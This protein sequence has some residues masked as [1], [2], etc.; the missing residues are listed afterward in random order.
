[1]TPCYLPTH[2]LLSPY[3]LP[4]IS[5]RTISLRT[6]FYLLRACYTQPGTDLGYARTSGEVQREQHTARGL[7]P[8]LTLV[9]RPS[10]PDPRPQ[11]P[12]PR[13]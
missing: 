8:H 12:D 5:L 13:P 1:M 11:T 9:P 10:T 4:A 3:A 2:F 6:F 7:S